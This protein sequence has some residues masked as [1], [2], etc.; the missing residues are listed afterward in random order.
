MAC[1]I[2][3]FIHFATN[4]S[5]CQASKEDNPNWHQV[6][7]GPFKEECWKAAL[8]DTIWVFMLKRFPDYKVKEFKMRFCACGD[9]Q[10]KGMDIFKEY[11]PVVQWRTVCSFSRFYL[12]LSQS[13]V[14]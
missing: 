11:A 3:R 1:P 5:K 4:D 12:N 8:K 14:M 2:S 13:T 6:M 7:A 10:L 9:Q